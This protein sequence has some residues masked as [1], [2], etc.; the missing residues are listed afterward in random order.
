MVTSWE[1]SRKE[2]ESHEA[3][4]RKTWGIF[5][6]VVLLV[7]AV[8]ALDGVVTQQDG[9]DLVACAEILRRVDICDI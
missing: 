6:V 4:T 1:K 7:N 8:V 9:V 2:S 5:T 3:V